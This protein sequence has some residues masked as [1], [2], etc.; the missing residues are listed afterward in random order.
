MRDLSP[1]LRAYPGGNAWLARRLDEVLAGE[2]GCNLSR[3][4]WGLRAITIET[5]KGHGQLKLSTFWVAPR[6]R[7]RG[8]GTALLH[9]SRRRW[10][11]DELEKVWVTVC[12]DGYQDLSAMLP[13]HG[14]LE[15]ATEMDRYGENR[16]EAIFI[17]HPERDPGT[18][19]NENNI[20]ALRT[21]APC[22]LIYKPPVSD[23]PSSRSRPSCSPGIDDLHVRRVSSRFHSRREAS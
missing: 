21:T 10:L 23:M 9:R 15:T 8:L 14:F 20:A 11:R 3:D 1:V 22:G 7:G 4:S 13:R 16:P 6:V 5:P 17:W 18:K 12:P 2:A 19:F